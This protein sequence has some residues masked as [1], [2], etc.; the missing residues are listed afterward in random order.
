VDAVGDA[1]GIVSSG[2]ARRAWW[3]ALLLLAANVFSFIDRTLLTLLVAPIRAELEAS[4]T[5]ISLLHG[6]AF[7]ALYAVMGLPL[8]RW[9]DRGDR[10]Y[11]MS[12]GVG[13]WSLMTMASGA[14]GSVGMLAVARAGVAVGEASLAPA[15]V[16]LLSERMPRAVVGRA[17]AI[18]QSGIFIGS[19]LALMVGG[20]L[21]KWFASIDPQSLGVFASWSPW[22]LVFLAAGA[23]GLLIAA[24]LLLVHEPRRAA[25]SNRVVGLDRSGDVRAYLLTHR[26]VYGWHVV[27]FTA[28][29]VLAYGTLAWVPT[30]LVRTHR[31]TTADAGLW[32]G[33]ILLVCG[34]L[35]VLAS[36]TLVDRRLTREHPDAPMRVA[37]IGMLVLAAAT[38][39]FALAPSRATALLA[40]VPLA[41]GLGFPYGIAASALA[42]I[43]PPP[44]RGQVT[45]IYLLISNLIGLTCGPLLVALCTDR[46][47]HND[48]AVRYSLALL[49]A[50]TVPIAAVALLRARIPFAA[51]WRNA[52]P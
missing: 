43:T 25:A 11:L 19:A 4:D 23:P 9:A 13:L 26:A 16:S 49:P 8:G 38:V 7:A 39:A 46:I 12:G 6:L 34:P 32:L 24:L 17:I 41:V 5:V 20:G 31:V 21:L 47:F 48:L 22:R 42:V 14:A 45:A 2:A 15:A 3:L 52:N 29:T 50:M 28:I 30:T 33:S 35:G 36:G 10:A 51:A 40:Y 1:D 37:L 27:A 44:L 18:F